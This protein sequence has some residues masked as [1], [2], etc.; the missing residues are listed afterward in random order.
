VRVAFYAP[1]KPPGHPVP[2]GDREMAR[3]WLRALE[4]GGHRPLLAARLRSYEGRGDGERQR[5]IA[6]LGARLARRLVGRWRAA[7][8][9][10]RP[11]CWLTYHPYYKAPDWIG[12]PVCAALGIPY[13]VAEAS[14]APRRAGGP[15]AAGHRATEQAVA[16]AAAVLVLNPRDRPCLEPLAGARLRAFAPFIDCRWWCPAGDREAQRAALAAR[17]GL[18]AGEPW[19][20]TVAMMRPGAKLASYRLLAAALGRLRARRWQL[21]VAGDGA[22]HGEVAACLRGAAAGRVTLTGR[23]GGEEVRA[24]LRAAD[25]YLWPAVDEAFGVALLE[26]AACALPVVAGRE[27]GVAAVVR[28]RLGGLLVAPRDPEALAAAAGALLDDPLRRAAMGAAAREQAVRV[29]GIETAARR[30]DAIL[31]EICRR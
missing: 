17:L 15:W 6:A 30:L 22:A 19:L 11:D 3:L 28:D 4:R 24:L 23:L 7:P 29:H 26:A 18:P 20:V 2:S 10:E 9:G 5:R 31:G 12:P 16:A 13:L 25:L 14:H 21:V 27:G 8:P 1:L